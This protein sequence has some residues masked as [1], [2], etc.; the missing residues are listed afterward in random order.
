[1]PAS[2]IHAKNLYQMKGLWQETVVPAF[3]HQNVAR[4]VGGMKQAKQQHFFRPSC[5]KLAQGSGAK[6]KKKIP[7]KWKANRQLCSSERAIS[8][9]SLVDLCHYVL[10]NLTTIAPTWRGKNAAMLSDRWLLTFDVKSGSVWS[11]GS[12]L[13]LDSPSTVGWW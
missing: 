3:H 8:Q 2:I 4:P 5:Q 13:V 9:L 1:M 6:R 11:K 12:R 10:R 7:Q